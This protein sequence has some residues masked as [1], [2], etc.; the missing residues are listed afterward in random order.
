MSDQ[1]ATQAET[2]AVFRTRLL[3]GLAQGLILFGL[4]HDN[5]DSHWSASF[6]QF[7][8]ALVTLTMLLPPVLV[9]SVGHLAWRRLL[10]W[11]GVLGLMLSGMAAYSEWRAGEVL[12]YAKNGVPSFHFWDTGFFL[13]PLLFVAWSLI[14]SSEISKRWPALYESYFETAWKFAVQLMFSLIFIGVFWAV[15]WLG[16]GLFGL[17]KLTFLRTLIGHEWFWMTATTLVIAVGLHLSDVRSGIVSG[18]RNLLLSMLSWLLPLLILL[19]GGFLVAILGVGLE[20]LW[21]TRHAT[22][23]LLGTNAFLVVLINAAWQAGGRADSM[24]RL[25]RYAVNGACALLLPL[26]LI[27]AYALHLRVAQ[28]GWTPDRILAAACVLISLLYAAGYAWAL[29]ASRRHAREHWLAAIATTNIRVAL[30]FVLCGL[31]LLSPL[32]D[33]ARLAVASQMAMLRE[34]RIDSDKFD[35]KFLRFQGARFG[36]AALVE[37]S[38]HA[39]QKI[40]AQAKR[41]QDMK[42]AWEDIAG[43]SATK[44]ERI[45]L[46]TKSEPLFSAFLA[47]NWEGRRYTPHC[48]ISASARCDAYIA[49][50]SGRGAKEILLVPQTYGD[51]VLFSQGPMGWQISATFESF[52]IM[53][54]AQDIGK[55]LQQGKFKRQAPVVQDLVVGGHLLHVRNVG[56]DKP[57]SG[58]ED[59]GR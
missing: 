27:A 47:Q 54:H 8:A 30:V 44:T 22:T 24:P 2:P 34:G 9:I 6:P 56:L 20:P 7:Y 42:N 29:F 21:G 48:L 13:V 58:E 25:L 36:E 59:Q 31:C 55:A 37:L 18:I 15:L 19:V 45:V 11:A 49:D 5:T 41:T 38:N 52:E 50:F 39:D 10:P 12:G 33:P 40:Q 57:G 28:Y 35:Y 1:Q 43:V 14:L 4:L 3:I 23:I 53:D 51:A 32:A 16:V 17:L 26:A 46:K